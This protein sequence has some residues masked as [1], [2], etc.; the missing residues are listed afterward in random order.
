MQSVCLLKQQNEE[1]I[2][3]TVGQEVTMELGLGFL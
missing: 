1:R 2:N 3:Q